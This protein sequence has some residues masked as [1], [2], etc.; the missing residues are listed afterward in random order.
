EAEVAALR[1]LR[2]AL[3]RSELGAARGADAARG[4]EASVSRLRHLLDDFLARAAA[5][6]DPAPA[7]RE[8]ER[9]L[10]SS[11]PA[12][13]ERL[14]ASLAVGPIEEAQLPPRLVRRMR[15][16][17]GELRL[18]TFPREDLSD[19]DAMARFVDAV[20]AVDPSATGVAVNLVAFGRTTQ[21]A[22][23]EAVAAAVVAIAL[24]LGLVWRR[25][26]DVALVLAPLALAALATAAAM[27]AL[28]VPFSFFN[29]V[30][31]PLMLGAGVDAGV[32]VVERARSVAPG[33]LLATTTARAVLYSTATTL[34]SF[35]TLALSSHRGLA[36]LGALLAA[37]MALTLAAN[38]VVL[39]A[40][41][42]V[43][44]RRRA[45]TRTR[46]G[47]PDPT[48]PSRARR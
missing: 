43:R 14:R 40:L 27:V 3:A 29:V 7:L 23:A 34:V 11:L 12:H 48:S 4:L 39:P 31:I 41:L 9:L 24:V 45:R 16:D 8:L 32:H 46:A 5:S 15:A 35:G 25:A 38:L 47:E 10:L 1:A 13:V 44:A 30:V 33:E 18:Q 20:R 17:D 19:S 36:G 28:D 2:D 26:G 6:D 21:L 37:G 42:A 22:F